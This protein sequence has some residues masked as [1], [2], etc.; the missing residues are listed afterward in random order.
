MALDSC[1]PSARRAGYLDAWFAASQALWLEVRVDTYGAAIKLNSMGK[2]PGLTVVLV[3]RCK[4]RLED[5]DLWEAEAIVTE[6]DGSQ[7]DFRS[8]SD[9]PRSAVN[10]ALDRMN[11]HYEG[12]FRGGETPDRMIRRN[13]AGEVIE[14]PG[15]D[16]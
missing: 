6:E 7:R 10:G 8:H 2:G 14:L 15:F 1:D 3:V 16:A 4:A 9:R 13:E 12:R 11:R 5:R